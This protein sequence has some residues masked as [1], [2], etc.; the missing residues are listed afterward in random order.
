[1]TI[2]VTGG[3]QTVT[4]L[5]GIAA[6]LVGGWA[7]KYGKAGTASASALATI[8]ASGGVLTI[9]MLQQ[10][11]AG[12]DQL[13]TLSS[14]AGSVTA[15][16][17]NNIDWNI[18]ADLFDDNKTNDSDIIVTFESTAA[19]VDEDTIATLVTSIVAGNNAVTWVEL[20]TDYTT[21]TTWAK[22]GLFTGASI[23]R[24][25]VRTAED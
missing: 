3:G 23:N 19:G 24:T 7:A 9:T 15:S 25:D 20:T 1:M 17:G 2:S 12:Y 6:A 8:T 11:S 21:N 13:I 22:T 18:N 16:N 10:D 5:T 14:A 4:T